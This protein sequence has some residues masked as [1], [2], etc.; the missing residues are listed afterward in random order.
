MGYSPERICPLYH[1]L[2]C[3]GILANT[4]RQPPVRGLKNRLQF[5]SSA[6]GYTQPDLTHYFYRGN[7]A[8]APN[9]STHNFTYVELLFLCARKEPGSNSCP[10]VDYPDWWFSC[11]LWVPREKCTVVPEF[12]PRCFRTTFLSSFWLL[13]TSADPILTLSCRQNS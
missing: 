6:P 2:C 7:A 4:V 10:W 1:Q 11:F 9:Y 8:V 5:Q 12:R 3:C 13:F